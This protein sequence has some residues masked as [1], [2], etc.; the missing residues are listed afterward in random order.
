[1]KKILSLLPMCFM[2]IMVYAQP[3]IKITKK[4]IYKVAEI[5]IYKTPDGT[6]VMEANYRADQYEDLCALLEEVKREWELKCNKAKD[7]G[8]VNEVPVKPNAIK[9]TFISYYLPK[10]P[11]SRE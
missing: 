7:K 8:K 6:K 9:S 4:P 11:Q 1:M 10:I 5:I 3:E 2:M